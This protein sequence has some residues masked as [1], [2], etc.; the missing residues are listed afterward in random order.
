MLITSVELNRNVMGTIL[1]NSSMYKKVT[2]IGMIISAMLIIGGVWTVKSVLSIQ[3]EHETYHKNDVAGT[4][5]LSNIIKTM[6][7]L[8]VIGRDLILSTDNNRTK[9]LYQLN[10][11]GY[12]ELDNEINSYESNYLNNNDSIE[13]KEIITIKDRYRAGMLLSA[14]EIYI[15]NN[16]IEASIALKSVTPDAISFFELMEGWSEDKIIVMNNRY[17]IISSLTDEI[18]TITM[19]L[20]AAIISFVLFGFTFLIRTT[21]HPINTIISNLV[22]RE[23]SKNLVPIPLLAGGEIGE[24]I[25]HINQFMHSLKE[26]L[27]DT[28]NASTKVINLS[29]EINT[30]IT[31]SKNNINEILSELD[32]STFATKDIVTALCEMSKMTVIAETHTQSNKCNVDGNSIKINQVILNVNQLDEAFDNTKKL[33]IA[34]V[35]ETNKVNHVINIISDIANQTNLLALNAAIEAAR[36]GEQGRGF[37]VVA[38]EVRTLASR[39]Q[40]STGE[41]NQII[42]SLHNQTEQVE[43]SLNDASQL[44]IAI[45]EELETAVKE[46]EDISNGINIITDMNT[47]ISSSTQRETKKS[48]EIEIRLSKVYENSENI[49]TLIETLDLNCQSLEKQSYY[50]REKSS[51]YSLK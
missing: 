24:V 11:Q 45:K 34:L 19:L 49:L 9:E 39:T 38:D 12:I 23:E 15:N 18:I 40:Q 26:T 42:S 8:R 47:V 51:I 1:F 3:Y 41:I 27:V 28:D 16:P 48:Q 31:E 7:Q 43:I 14:D 13:F 17:S 33:M 32:E 36:A 6:Y 46:F 21:V 25:K 22:E 37:A 2:F 5:Q 20:F 50:L 30:V 35:N 10:K 4:I 29:S 44:S